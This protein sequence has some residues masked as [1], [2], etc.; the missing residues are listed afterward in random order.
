MLF[1]M[2]NTSTKL[3]YKYYCCHYLDISIPP[4]VCVYCVCMYIFLCLRM[5]VFFIILKLV[6][7]WE[8]CYI[9]M[10]NLF[11]LCLCFLICE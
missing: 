6:V 5:C 4:C 11:V 10:Y 1:Q 3:A 2:N 9:I 8:I 7:I